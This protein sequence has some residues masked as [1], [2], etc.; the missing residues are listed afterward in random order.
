MEWVEGMVIGDAVAWEDIF[1]CLGWVLCAL[2]VGFSERYGLF[3]LIFVMG[4]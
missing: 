2:G 3:R 1:I 4:C